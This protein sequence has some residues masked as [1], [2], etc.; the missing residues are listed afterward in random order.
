MELTKLYLF[1][2]LAGIVHKMGAFVIRVVQHMV[3]V[4]YPCHP[5]SVQRQFWY[6][7]VIIDN[8]F[9]IT[10][11]PE[12]GHITH[13]VVILFNLEIMYFSPVLSQRKLHN[14]ENEL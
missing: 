3:I 7:N 2:F 5:V 14:R 13:L 10:T 4:I 12:V 8:I 6:V 1:I 9:D 11:P